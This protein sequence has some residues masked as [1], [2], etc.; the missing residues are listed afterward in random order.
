MSAAALKRRISVAT[1]AGAL[2]KDDH[3]THIVPTEKE[4]V[5]V[6][7]RPNIN[8]A[9]ATDGSNSST[10]SLPSSV[11]PSALATPV[12]LPVMPPLPIKNWTL[13]KMIGQGSFG[14]VY[15]ALNLDNGEFMAV[16]Q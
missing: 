10:R 12:E 5:V 1:N 15:M 3:S 13:G 8:T 9:V 14:R 11:N 16:K 6:D 7:P 2:L 4:A